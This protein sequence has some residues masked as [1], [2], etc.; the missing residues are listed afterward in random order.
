MLFLGLVCLLLAA[1]TLGL[2]LKLCL[3]YRGLTE[4]EEGVAFCLSQDTNTLLRVSV[5]DARLCRFAHALSK[6]LAQMSGNELAAQGAVL[7]FP[8]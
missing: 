5:R 2:S 3:L 7:V 6:Q 1:A 8:A 4:L